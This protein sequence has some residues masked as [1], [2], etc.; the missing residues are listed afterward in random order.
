MPLSVIRRIVV[1]FVCLAC[2]ATASPVGGHDGPTSAGSGEAVVLDIDGAIGPATSDY[3][4][5]GLEQAADRGAAIVI[6]RIDTPGG[7][8]TA[9]RDIVRAILAAPLPVV[10][11]VA[12][13]GARAASAGTYITYASHVAAMAPGTNLGAATP[14]QIG[15]PGAPPASPPRDGERQPAV[16]KDSGD[17]TGEEDAGETQPAPP[18]GIGEKARSDA[19]AYIRGLAQL[20]GRNVGWAEKAV[21]KAASLSAEDALAQGV[22]DVIA[23]DIPEL[24]RTIDGRTVSVAGRPVTLATKE[25]AVVAFEPDWRT[26]LLAIIT[27]P[28]VAYILMLVGIYGILFEFYSPGLVGPGVIGAICLLLAL[29]A[30]QVLPVNY[31]G[32][33]L[34]LL[35]VAMLTAEAFVPSF[36]ILGLAG[37]AALVVGS[38]ML[39]DGDVPGFTLAWGLIAGVAA[40]SGLLFTTVLTLAVR[41]RRQAVVSGREGM[42]GATGPVVRWNGHDGSVRVHGEVWRARARRALSPGQRIQ[43]SEVDGLTL[44]VEPEGQHPDAKHREP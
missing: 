25:L 17:G 22:I 26:R 11:F 15:G 8:D 29:Y 21:S 2:F 33:A 4:I 43:V 31:A 20:R 34:A 32:V 41:S 12:P 40:A 5:R 9:M 39:M 27:N 28:N 24:L 1:V 7:L 42:I 3:V 16:G 35:G 6:L 10:A 23:A 30:F 14:V 19:I 18:P 37:I 38:I 44:V 36:G 13:G